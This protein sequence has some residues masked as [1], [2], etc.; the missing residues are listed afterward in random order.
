MSY[1]DVKVESVI[2][3]QRRIKYVRQSKIIY[4]KENDGEYR[5]D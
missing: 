2:E 4:M 3:R 5:R 1:N